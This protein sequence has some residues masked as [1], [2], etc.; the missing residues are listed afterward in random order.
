MGSHRDGQGWACSLQSPVVRITG[1]TGKERLRHDLREPRAGPVEFVTGPRAEDG[2]A[3][4]REKWLGARGA[5]HE[6]AVDHQSSRSGEGRWGGASV[7]PVVAGGAP[8][9]GVARFVPG[10][11][12]LA[13]GRRSGAGEV[14]GS[15][16]DPGK[17][18][19]RASDPAVVG[20]GA[21]RSQS[22]GR[23]GWPRRPGGEEEGGKER[24]WAGGAGWWG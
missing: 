2:W 20:G 7:S 16:Y 14:G 23:R 19:R 24:E 21:A 10:R 1:D 11:G 15:R 18:W 9:P 3:A 6:E 12:G 13:V 8:Q 4:R 17:A 5:V 22:G